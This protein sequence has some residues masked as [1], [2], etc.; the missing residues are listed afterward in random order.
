ML[1]DYIHIYGVPEL[2]MSIVRSADMKRTPDVRTRVALRE[3]ACTLNVSMVQPLVKPNA[4]ANLLAA[5]GMTVGVGDWRGEKG[6]GNYGMFHVADE[7][8]ADLKRIMK[9]GRTVQEEAMRNPTAFDDETA[10]LLTWF[11][12][13]LVNRHA[14]GKGAVVEEMFVEPET[15]DDE[16]TVV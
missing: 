10:D 3:W 6:S 15:V 12:E 9:N 13:E 2:F 5:A 14:K 11:N 7:D 1:G 16:E 8:D 4:V